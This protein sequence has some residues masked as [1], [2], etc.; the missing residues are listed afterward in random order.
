MG[1]ELRLTILKSPGSCGAG[2][3]FA[4]DFWEKG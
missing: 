3:A 2:G 1:L 4:L